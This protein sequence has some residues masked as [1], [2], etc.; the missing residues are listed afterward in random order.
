VELLARQMG[1]GIVEMG[2]ERD[3]AF[4]AGYSSTRGV[5]TWNDNM[6]IL[7]TN[8]FIKTHRIAGRYRYVLIVHPTTVVQHLRDSNKV[9]REWWDAYVERKRET[10]EPTFEQREKKKKTAK[11]VVPIKAAL[12]KTGTKTKVG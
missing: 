9:S 1:E 4:A 12:K 5:R 7:E 10:K 2:H 6:K 11:N 8:G 3:H